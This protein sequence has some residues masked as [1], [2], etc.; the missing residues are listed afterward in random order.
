MLALKNGEAV[1]LLPD[2]VPPEGLGVW[3][4]FFGEP[5]Y[6]MTLSVRFASV[7]GT[8]VLSDVGRAPVVGAGLHRAR[9]PV[10]RA[11]GR[12]HWPSA[13]KTLPPR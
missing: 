10:E 8:Q 9:A 7:P 3:A 4:P 13:P 1:G 2:Q 12:A 11:D 6:T 5:A